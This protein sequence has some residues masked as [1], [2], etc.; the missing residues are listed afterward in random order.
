MQRST[1]SHP[2]SSYPGQE[3]LLK[4]TCKES[5]TGALKWNLEDQ[6]WILNKFHW[7]VQTASGSTSILT[8]VDYLDIFLIYINIIPKQ[9]PSRSLC[10]VQYISFQLYLIPI[11]SARSSSTA[12]RLQ[13]GPIA[14]ACTSVPASRAWYL[15]SELAHLSN[16]HTKCLI[17]LSYSYCKPFFAWWRKELARPLQICGL[18][19]TSISNIAEMMFLRAL[20]NTSHQTSEQVTSLLCLAPSRA[21][22]LPWPCHLSHTSYV[23]ELKFLEPA[24]ICVI[25]HIINKALYMF[26]KSSA[27]V[28]VCWENTSLGYCFNSL[29]KGPGKESWPAFVWTR[30]GGPVISWRSK[31]TQLAW[32]SLARPYS[33]S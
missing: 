21:S 4:I 15:K 3:G 18:L 26:R 32:S 9:Q 28:L 17:I 5:R 2:C 25:S 11:C 23:Q 33:W 6:S 19:E 30:A 27:F 16:V 8:L 1:Y 29:E 13:V 7:V 10:S 12:Q 24:C 22:V 14:A 20:H 31:G